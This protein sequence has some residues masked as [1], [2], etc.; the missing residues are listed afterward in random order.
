MEGKIDIKNF[1]VISSKKKQN[2]KF[3]FV[4]STRLYPEWPFAK[5]NHTPDK[6]AEKVSMALIAMPKNSTGA[7][8]ARCAGWTIPL[9]YQPVYECLKDLK[10]GHYK[11]LGEI[12]RTDVFKKYPLS[13]STI[14]F[15]L[16]G[17]Q[18]KINT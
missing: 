13:I 17:Q 8:A 15:L 2:A 14:A 11:D 4:H 3:P 6:L 12:T 9:S 1:Y 7:G 5:L 18:I 10:L 16:I